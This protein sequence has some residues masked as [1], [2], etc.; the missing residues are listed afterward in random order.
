MPKRPWPSKRVY[1]FAFFP[2]KLS[3]DLVKLV[4]ETGDFFSISKFKGG[5]FVLILMSV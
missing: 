1:G 5:R 2:P 4:I 3:Q